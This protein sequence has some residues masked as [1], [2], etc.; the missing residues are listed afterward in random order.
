MTSFFGLVKYVGIGVLWVIGI[1]VLVAAI[2]SIVFTL[3]PHELTGFLRNS[4]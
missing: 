1:A 3:S 2:T 4:N